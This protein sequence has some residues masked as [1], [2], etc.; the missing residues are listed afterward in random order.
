MQFTCCPTSPWQ[1]DLSTIV[2][3]R[4]SSSSCTWWTDVEK[5]IL[6]FQRREK[7]ARHVRTILQY[8][9][10]QPSLNNLTNAGC[11][12]FHQILAKGLMQPERGAIVTPGAV[13]AVAGL[14]RRVPVSVDRVDY[15]VVPPIPGSHSSAM[16]SS[17][18]E[19]IRKMLY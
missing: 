3:W 5:Q 1:V 12:Y 10:N 19:G 14:A 17:R 8:R 16:Q 2:D 11:V 9:R 4:D 15:Q 7:N 18:E 6:Q 13:T